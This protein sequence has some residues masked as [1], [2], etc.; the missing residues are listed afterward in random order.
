MRR[1]LLPL[2]LLGLLGLVVV[3]GSVWASSGAT[4]PAWGVAIEVPGT[5]TLNSGGAAHV[6]AVSCVAAGTCAAG[7]FYTDSSFDG[8]QTFVVDEKN[9]SL[10]SGI[11]VPRID[12]L[13]SCSI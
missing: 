1:R 8:Q 11:P 12:T 2:S 10:G 6:N 7:G 5:A 13:T 4:P 3:S 9:G